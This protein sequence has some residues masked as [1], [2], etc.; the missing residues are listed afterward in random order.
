[1]TRSTIAMLKVAVLAAAVL[2]VTGSAQTVV[3]GQSG[4]KR[5]GPPRTPWGDPDLQGT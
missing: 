5:T 1:M 4:Q 2:G 3:S